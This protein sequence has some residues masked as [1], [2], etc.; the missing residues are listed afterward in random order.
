M[1]ACDTDSVIQGEDKISIFRKYLLHPSHD[2][3]KI[4]SLFL[5]NLNL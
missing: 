4:R 1:K 3:K 5:T 2:V